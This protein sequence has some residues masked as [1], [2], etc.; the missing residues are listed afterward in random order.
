MLQYLIFIAAI[1]QLMG[2][3]L[4][5]KETLKGKNKPNKITWLIWSLAPFIGTAAAMSN[6][7]G[8]AVLPVFMSGFGPFLIFIS[9]FYNPQSYWKLGFFDY[10]C[11]ALAI[12]A[13]V[14][15]AI[16]K[17][18]IAAILLAIT[19]DVLA[20]IPTVIKTWRYPETETVQPYIT[21]LF[22]ALTG[23]FA[24]K[25]WIL[26]A[27]AFITYLALLDSFVVIMYYYRL[28]KKASYA[29]NQ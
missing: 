15:W 26:S 28:K 24:I 10:V 23:F 4:Y 20:A 1:V 13:L 2:S 7:V 17:Q 6:G 22:G 27:Y 16:T 25:V 8:W 18:P 9:S 12:L 29:Q 11:G 21:S 14:L 19:S 3:L 5:V